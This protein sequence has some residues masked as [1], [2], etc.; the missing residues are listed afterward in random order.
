MIGAVTL[1]S[2]RLSEKR[3]LSQLHSVSLPVIESTVTLRERNSLFTHPKK[4]SVRSRAL[5]T[6][7]K[8]FVCI[9]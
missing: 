1:A 5:C 6:A 3:H 9:V 2:I 8:N 4:L 7:T